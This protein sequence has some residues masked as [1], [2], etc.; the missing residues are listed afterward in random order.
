MRK[1]LTSLLIMLFLVGAFSFFQNVALADSSYNYSETL[2]DVS[3]W[4]GENGNS[5]IAE[6]TRSIA[7]SLIQIIQIVGTGVAIVMLTYFGMK[8]MLAAPDAKADFKKSATGYIVGAVL[9]FASVNIIAI[10]SNFATSN[11]K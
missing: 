3:G 8:Y 9:L 4:P 5:D 7:A 10:I 1:I 6:K 11:I 2:K